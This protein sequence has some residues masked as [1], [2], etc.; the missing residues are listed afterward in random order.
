MILQ[1]GCAIESPGTLEVL[2]KNRIMFALLQQVG[3]LLLLEI[4]LVGIRVR[5][6]R[7]SR[8]KIGLLL[9]RLVDHLLGYVG[10]CEL[11]SSGLAHDV[12]VVIS[13]LQ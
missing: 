4:Q 8:C 11:V 9:L 2:R 6:H 13:Q 5:S 12:V 10:R 7:L 1:M 3:V